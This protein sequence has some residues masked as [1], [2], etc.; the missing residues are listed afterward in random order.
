MRKSSI[1]ASASPGPSIL[2]RTQPESGRGGCTEARP[3]AISSSRIFLGK[4]KSAKLDPQWGLRQ[5]IIAPQYDDHLA[6][7]DD[8]VHEASEEYDKGEPLDLLAHLAPR[9][10]E[11]QHHAH[12]R[13][14]D[15]QR[16]Q[17]EYDIRHSHQPG[18]LLEPKRVEH[19]SL[20]L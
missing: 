9:T 15:A 5:V 18:E 20:V 16:Q 4:G 3:S 10:P 2:R 13:S 17:Q 14:E 8:K 19:P 11:A 12:R 7:H 6:D 1:T